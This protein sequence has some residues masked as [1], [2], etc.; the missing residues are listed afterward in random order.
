MQFWLIICLIQLLIN[1]WEMMVWHLGGA[2]EKTSIILPSF[3]W[4]FVKT[5]RYCCKPHCIHK[6]KSILFN[7]ISIPTNMLLLIVLF[8]VVYYAL[9]YRTFIHACHTL[10]HHLLALEV[11]IDVFDSIVKPLIIQTPLVI[12]KDSSYEDSYDYPICHLEA[13]NVFWE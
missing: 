8:M 7:I 6:Y 2:H 12:V 9:F 1:L 11:D 3:D 4:C 13:I 10:K 5:Q